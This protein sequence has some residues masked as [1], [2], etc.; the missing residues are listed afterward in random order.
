MTIITNDDW[1]WVGDEYKVAYATTSDPRVLAVIEREEDW[2]GGHIFGDIYA[3]AFYFERGRKSAAGSTYTDGESEEIAEAWA[4]ARYYYVNRQYTHP[5]SPRI[6]VERVL[7]RYMRCF[8]GTEVA[9][10]H[11]TI[12]RGS[13]VVIFNTPSW[14]EHVGLTDRQINRFT[15]TSFDGTPGSGY[16][17][18]TV[19]AATEREARAIHLVNHPDE[20]RKITGAHRETLLAGNAEEWQA[21]LDGDVFGVGWAV[22]RGRALADDEPIDLDFGWD[23]EIECW[24][25]LTEEYAKQS[26]AAFDYG[27]PDLPEMLDFSPSRSVD[28]TDRLAE[29]LIREDEIA[30]RGL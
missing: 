30:D 27:A 29:A 22:N 14:R 21:A 10:V 18:E 2:G 6:D 17:K 11:S 3:P 13:F 4:T 25:V 7:E 1:T 26:A 12:N 5:R 28:H 16:I 20:G 19:D 8:W 24:G 15:V 9:E 23:V